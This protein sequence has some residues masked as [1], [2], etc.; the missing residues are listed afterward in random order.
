MKNNSNDVCCSII[1][2]VYNA[3]MYIKDCLD[4]IYAQKTNFSFEVIVV[5]D[6]STDNS[7]K[8]VH[9]YFPQARI[10]TKTNGGPGSARNHGVK[11]ALSDIIL[12]IDAD[13]VMLP[14]RIQHQVQYMIQ[15]PDVKLCFGAQ[16]YQKR[17]NYNSNIDRKLCVDDN[18]SIVADAYQK[19][20]VNG[21]YIANTA[22]A[23]RKSVYLETG[24]QPEDIFVAE[25]YC[26][27]CNVARL[28]PVAACGKFLTWYRQEDHQNLMSS[29][30]TYI[31]PPKVLAAQ[32]RFY[33]NFLSTEDNSLA[34]KR[35]L[36]LINML[37]GYQWTVNGRKSIYREMNSYKDFISFHFQL[38]WFLL[39]IFPSILPQTVRKIKNYG[40]L[41]HR[42]GV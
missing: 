1:I 39:S 4:S 6:G 25:D 37:L 33:S 11:E 5:N 20:L 36:K 13:D 9:E 29:R 3:E 17:K 42:E 19:L 18:F 35:L 27:C 15:T 30:H 31:G 38:K 8:I 34:K 41:T 12:F 26:M 28:Y 7:A 16:I 24:G 14:D 40:R 2:P 10:L 21:N 23:I 22:T 32:L